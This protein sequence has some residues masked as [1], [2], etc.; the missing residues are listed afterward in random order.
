MP[1][2]DTHIRRYLPHVMLG[3]IIALMAMT[4][5]FEK[6]C[7]RA[8]KR[9]IEDSEIVKIEASVTAD[10]LDKEQIDQLH[11]ATLKASDSCFELKKIC[12]TVLVPASS[13]VSLLSGQKLNGA[14][15]VSAL[16]IITAFWLADAVGYFYQRKLRANMTRIWQRRAARCPDGYEHIPAPQRVGAF[17]SA[18]NSSMI[19][20][21]LLSSLVGLAFLLY[22]LGFISPGL[23][24]KP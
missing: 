2:N 6:T 19:Y 5:I 10:D 4:S 20:Y 8:P 11:A 15:F 18:F 16:L 22:F 21:L 24:S 14:V 13:L 23:S 1:I 3:G 12:A 17:R 7:K 9:N